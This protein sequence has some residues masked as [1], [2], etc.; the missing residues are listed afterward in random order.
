MEDPCSSNSKAALS[1]AKPA[2]ITTTSVRFCALSGLGAI[3]DAATAPPLARTVRRESV[4]GSLL[5]RIEDFKGNTLSRFHGAF[6]APVGLRCVLAAEVNTLMRF[7][8]LIDETA[9]LSG[10]P[11]RPITG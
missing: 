2:P 11:H 7:C 10:L 9:D 6:H 8:H 1:P 5:D 3:P 4:V